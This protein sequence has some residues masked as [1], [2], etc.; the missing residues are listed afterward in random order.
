V[1]LCLKGTPQAS[2]VFNLFVKAFMTVSF[3]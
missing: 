1:K 2:Y 3:F